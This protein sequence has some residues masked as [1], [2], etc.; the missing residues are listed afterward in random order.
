MGSPHPP[1]RDQSQPTMIFPH[2]TEP[3]HPHIHQREIRLQRYSPC[4]S[5]HQSLSPQIFLH[6][7]L[8]YHTCGRRL[9]HWPFPISLPLLPLLHPLSSI[10]QKHGH[11]RVLPEALRLPQDNQPHLSSPSIRG[12]HQHP[13]QQ[14][15]RLF[16][17]FTIF[18]SPY[19]QHLLTGC[20]YPATCCPNNTYP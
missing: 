8:L 5:W 1:G 12:H 11:G 19:N 17:P 3:F 15:F 7:T 16:S 4:S 2:K 9:V 14:K 20:T 10:H 13:V 6:P 18:W